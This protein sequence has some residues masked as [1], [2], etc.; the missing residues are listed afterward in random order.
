MPAKSKLPDF[1][2]DIATCLARI[3]DRR[4]TVA[5]QEDLGLDVT[6]EV[7]AIEKMEAALADLKRARREIEAEELEL[8]DIEKQQQELMDAMESS[9]VD[10]RC[11]LMSVMCISGSISVDIMT[12]LERIWHMRAAQ[13]LSL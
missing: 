12:A 2:E 1:D 4:A 9:D 3:E 11:V 7:A 13:R 6:E 5:E 8:A 10:A